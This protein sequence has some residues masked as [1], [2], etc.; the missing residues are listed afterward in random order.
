MRLAITNANVITGDGETILENCSV[1]AENE[2]IS[3]IP[4]VQ[5]LYY[6]PADRIIDAHG[7]IV[8]PGII[9]HHQHGATF[10]PLLATGNPPLP[11][12]RVLANLDRL[13]CQGVTTVQSQDGLG[14][15]DEVRRADKIHPINVKTGTAHT[16][17]NLRLA[18]SPDFQFGGIQKKHWQTTVDEMAQLGASC[19]GELGTGIDSHYADTILLPMAIKSRTGQ[20]L[21]PVDARKLHQLAVGGQF[22]V[23]GQRLRELQ[24]AD[25]LSIKGFQEVLDQVAQWSNLAREAAHEGI[26]AA[27]RLNLP[28][29][30]H[31]SPET[32]PLV[33]D[34]AE[35]LGDRLIAAHCNYRIS[36]EEAV[37]QASRLRRLGA[38]LDIHTGDM[39][40]VRFFVQS[41]DVTYALFRNGL[42]D[43]ISTDYIGG[44][45]DSILL[46]L[47]ASVKAGHVTLAK[48]IATA[49]SNVV[50]AFPRLAP[51][52]GLLAPG[53][54]ADIVI[55]NREH[56][57][58]VETVII[59]GKVV[60]ERQEDPG[61]RI[62]Y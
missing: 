21:S 30:M 19:V 42:V 33:L 23:V 57:G 13:L 3:D 47:E 59:G 12:A 2:I 16:P 32:E 49:T 5:F 35:S 52:R 44:Y 14:T 26:E 4:R 20:T 55:V 45:W 40:G 10:S 48:A 62:V 46:T 25:H 22:E 31:N 28:A 11:E 17:K 39:F 1:I 50:K 36:S 9:T 54:I 6:D 7:N 61:L 60:V 37:A 18:D 24:M 51:N 27:R 43:L 8:I 29:V 56:I 41:P 38:Y 15:M 53:K 58:R 34:A